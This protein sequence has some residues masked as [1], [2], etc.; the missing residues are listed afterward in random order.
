MRDCFFPLS[1]TQ[2]PIWTVCLVRCGTS[3]ADF[4]TGKGGT[5]HLLEAEGLEPPE[6]HEAT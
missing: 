4:G 5:E 3:E 1:Y 6:E 2:G